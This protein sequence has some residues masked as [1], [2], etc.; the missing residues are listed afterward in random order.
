MWWKTFSTPFINEMVNKKR[1]YVKTLSIMFSLVE[2]TS[3]KSFPN[4]SKGRASVA[5]A[6][7]RNSIK[8]RAVKAASLRAPA[9]HGLEG[10]GFYATLD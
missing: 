10:T 6:K 4:R 2:I 3:I 5:V 9:G 7:F 1:H 8:D